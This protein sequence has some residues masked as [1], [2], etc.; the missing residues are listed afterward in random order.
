MTAPADGL[1]RTPILARRLAALRARLVRGIL[2]HALGSVA[3]VVAAWL[4]FTYVADRWLG[5][6]LAVR[7]FHLALLLALPAFVAWREG[8]RHLRRVP[9]PAG[10]A[11]LA[12]RGRPGSEELFVSAVQFQQRTGSESGLELESTLVD[13]VL[14]RAESAAPSIDA[15]AVLESAAPRRRAWAGLGASALTVLWLGLLPPGHAAIFGA[16]LF[17][18]T[19]PWPQRTFLA[20]ELPAA[21]GSVAITREGEVIRAR[22]ARG[23]DLPVLVRAEGQVP[24]SVTLELDDGRRIE[25]AAAREGL[26]RTEL[27]ALSEDLSFSVVGGDDRD[28]LPRAEIRVLQPPDLTGY[29]IVVEPPAYTGLAPERFADRSARAVIGSRVEVRLTTT[30]GVIEAAVELLPSAERLPLDPVPDSGAPPASGEGELAFGFEFVAR[31]DL[32]LR[33]LLTDG[34]GLANPDPGLVAI[35]VVEDRAPEIALVAPGRSNVESVRGGALALRARVEDDFGLADVRLL[36]RSADDD[37]RELVRSLE[38][39]P[40]GGDGAS[41]RLHQ[42]LEIDA[43]I[44][45]L[46]IDAATSVEQLVLELEASDVAQP[47]QVGRAAPVRVRLLSVDELLRRV[48]DRLAAAR[49]AANEL[50]GLQ[51]ERRERTEELFGALSGDGALAAADARAV[52]GMLSGQRRV[53]SDAEALVRELASTAE[54][55]L[56]A[57]LDPSGDALLELL[58]AESATLLERSFDPGPWRRLSELRASST[59]RDGF[60][61]HL[62]EIVDL[63]LRVGDAGSAAVSALGAAE[64]AASLSESRSGLAEALDAQ[65]RTAA[66]IEDLLDRLAEWDNFQSVLALT[67][68]ILDRQRAVRDRLQRLA[69]EK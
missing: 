9:G 26:F 6:P 4:A 23:S 31:E 18:A 67:R 12:E 5:V 34:D 1:D 48:Q 52:A 46:A 49:V 63:G 64:G 44:A 60:A 15:S 62:V 56:Y 16:R 3:V 32:R 24:S 35:E 30:P 29:E 8:W 40:M 11:V 39:A 43:L 22:V 66:R 14:E 41:G 57:R 10:L 28:G 21:D 37:E 58:D 25:L 54:L 33:F 50:A 27:P 38:F 53:A 42:L 45:E 17:G 47:A 51:R 59:D 20:L 13:R 36:V 2:L 68:D 55:V 69:A 61:S 65:A 19:T 7:W